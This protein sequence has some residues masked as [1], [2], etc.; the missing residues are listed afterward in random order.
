MRPV[1]LRRRTWTGRPDT[2]APRSRHPP[3]TTR[4]ADAV[5]A[6]APG[7]MRPDELERRLRE[8]L[9]AL[10]PAPRAELLHVL[11]LPDFERA[12]KIGEPLTREITATGGLQLLHEVDTSALRSIRNVTLS[13]PE[14]CVDARKPSSQGLRTQPP[15]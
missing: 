7:S 8:R 13:L 4:G 2:Q 14:F 15:S 12:D 10:G 9:D 11:M 5:T 6:Y 3:C 1:I